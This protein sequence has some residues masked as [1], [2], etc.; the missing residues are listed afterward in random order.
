MFKKVYLK[1]YSMMVLFGL[2]ALMV[3]VASANEGLL[4][5]E[6]MRMR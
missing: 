4:I 5:Y 2:M 1:I 6:D 3:P